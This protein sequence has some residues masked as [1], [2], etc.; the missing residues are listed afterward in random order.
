MMARAKVAGAKE[1]TRRWTRGT[2]LPLS[3]LGDNPR[4]GN[5]YGTTESSSRNSIL[6]CFSVPIPS[7]S[8]P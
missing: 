8:L 7:R 6:R 2:L 4:G 1:L 3:P 5:L